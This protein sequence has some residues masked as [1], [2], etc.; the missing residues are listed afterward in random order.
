MHTKHGRQLHIPQF[1]CIN[2]YTLSNF[3]INDVGIYYKV[4]KCYKIFTTSYSSSFFYLEQRMYK[5]CF[6]KKS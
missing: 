1:F 6:Y 2:G 3:M 5:I 4:V